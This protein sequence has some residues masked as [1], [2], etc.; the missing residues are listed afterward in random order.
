MS[1]EEKDPLDVDKAIE[2]LNAA[3]PV[4]LRSGSPT[5]SPPA[6]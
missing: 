3:L 5:R 6:R 1:D 2:L 4:Q